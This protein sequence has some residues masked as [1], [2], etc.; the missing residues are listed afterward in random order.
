MSQEIYNLVGDPSQCWLC[1]R[2][3]GEE[4]PVVEKQGDR[5]LSESTKKI[6]IMRIGEEVDEEV[7]FVCQ[8]CRTIFRGLHTLMHST[9]PLG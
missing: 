1:R 8:S 2:Q 7:Y 3:D 5:V 4:V 6:E 9:T